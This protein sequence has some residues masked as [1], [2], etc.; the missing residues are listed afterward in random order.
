[1]AEF[2]V[3]GYDGQNAVV[4]VSC[5][6]SFSCSECNFHKIRFSS[7]FLSVFRVSLSKI[8]NNQYLN[9][10]QLLICALALKNFIFCFLTGTKSPRSVMV[11]TSS[12]LSPE[13]LSATTVTAPVSSVHHHHYSDVTGQDGDALK[14]RKRKA[15]KQE[16][17]ILFCNFPNH[18]GLVSKAVVNG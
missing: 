1:M 14:R 18:E 5:C 12:P 7:Y 3:Y 2:N 15:K 11:T 9:R 17:D 6:D 8:I 4:F 10:N 16:Q 13:M